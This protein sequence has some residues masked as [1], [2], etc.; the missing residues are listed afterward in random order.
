MYVK[1]TGVQSTKG[2]SN[3]KYEMNNQLIKIS[4]K[5]NAIKSRFELINDLMHKELNSR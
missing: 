2:G 5:Q 3:A 4:G 1:T